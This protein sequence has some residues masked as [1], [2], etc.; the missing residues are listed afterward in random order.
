MPESRE[1][2]L[3]FRGLFDWLWERLP[4]ARPHLAE[5][6]A[7]AELD[8]VQEGRAIP[9]AS[10]GYLLNPYGIL[11]DALFWPVIVP[12]VE[13]RND[14]LLARTAAIVEALLAAADEDIRDAADLRVVSPLI[15]HA[16]Y[17]SIFRHVAGPRLLSMTPRSQDPL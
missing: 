16:E 9:D 6:K 1:P 17:W 2:A 15:G 11:S 12:A 8:A 4:E 14:D 5:L 13:T 3:T 7:D 10:V